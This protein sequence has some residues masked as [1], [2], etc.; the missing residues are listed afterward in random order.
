[1][2]F[3]KLQVLEFLHIKLVFFRFTNLLWQIFF[4]MFHVFAPGYT[5]LQN[6]ISRIPPPP[7]QTLET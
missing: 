4:D 2:F 3:G 1:M 7:L 6:H 5:T